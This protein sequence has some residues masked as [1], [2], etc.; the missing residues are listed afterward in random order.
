MQ[1]NLV[2]SKTLWSQAP[3]YSSDLFRQLYRLLLGLFSKRR[4]SLD[5]N[6]CFV[7]LLRI[8][9]PHADVTGCFALTG[10]RL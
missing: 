10:G 8:G 5:W 4:A 2:C 9:V 7:D 3:V 6:V 1:L